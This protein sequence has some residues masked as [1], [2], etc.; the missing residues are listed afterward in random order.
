M[1]IKIFYS[2]TAVL[3]IIAGIL[4]EYLHQ[5]SIGSFN[6]TLFYWCLFF[7][8]IAQLIDG[9]LGMAYGVSASTFLMSIGISPIHASAYVHISEIF[10]TGSSALS[11]WRFKN[12][13][14]KLFKK[15]VI[16]GVLGGLLGAY[17]LTR[18]KIPHLS[19]I[20]SIYLLLMGLFILSKAFKKIKFNVSYKNNKLIPLA[21]TGGFVDAIG[22]GGWGPIVTTG[23]IG[24]GYEPRR[25]IGTVNTSEF[26]VNIGTGISLGLLVNLIDWE[27]LAG[28][29]IGGLIISPFAA[30]LVSRMN[31]KILLIF[32]GCLI[33]FLS[34]KR[35]YPLIIK[36]I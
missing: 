21:A 23:L 16:P 27:A 7:G 32:V 20:I 22:G 6:Y 13:D 31:T 30:K 2:L 8:M 18:V 28:L 26:F 29:L 33:T 11:H 34:L 12:I 1:K 25:A 36:L 24:S 10:T 14:I 19:L 35:L 9:S 15:L 4:L 5:R 3:L 17:L